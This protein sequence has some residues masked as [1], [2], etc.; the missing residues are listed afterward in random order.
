MADDA[1]LLEAWRAGDRDA[2]DELIGR[3]FDPVCRFFRSKVDSD[4][5]D[6]VQRTF[7]DALERR[8]EISAPSFRS[9]L[10]AVARH[11]LF[12][13]LRRGLRRPIESLGETSIADVRTRQSTKMVRAQQND[14]V[15]QALQTLP[16]DF[17]IA[18]E[19]T[20]WEDLSGQEV[21]AVL[22]VSPHTVRSR[23]SRGRAKLRAAL[24]EQAS[25][26]EARRSL[27]EFDQRV[28]DS[29]ES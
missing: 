7:L 21:A 4:V 11:R 1:A 20:Y 6:L 5:E 15:V 28:G 9:Y 23:L 13:D 16:V 27:A 26:P 18:L 19:L 24:Q 12:D 29:E 3:Y 17:Q 25:N 10:F 22:G 2:G 8:D 14:L